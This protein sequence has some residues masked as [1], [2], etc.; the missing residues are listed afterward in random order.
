MSARQDLELASKQAL[1]G[2]RR[3]GP[4]P[5]GRTLVFGTYLMDTDP[6]DES[7]TPWLLSIGFWEAWVHIAIASLVKKGMYCVDVGANMGYFTLLMARQACAPC[8][9]RV[10]AIEPYPPSVAL[11]RN[12]IEIN[13]LQTQV[14]VLDAAV[15]SHK[16]LHVHI[17]EK[18]KGGVSVTPMTHR[19]GGMEGHAPELRQDTPLVV[20]SVR[21]IT[22]DDATA[23]MRRV[24]FVK[25]DVEGSEVEVWLT[26]YGLRHKNPR[27]R[28]VIE[29]SPDRQYDMWG[30][31][32]QMEDEGNEVFMVTTDG[33]FVPMEQARPTMQAIH[34]QPGQYATIMVQGRR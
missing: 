18:H 24:D 34:K 10:L 2:W 20:Q 11:L 32:R 33:G 5:Q 29:V 30:L 27:C 3:R 26:S 4:Q 6:E 21:G 17:P 9:G 22:L 25:V 15:S 1:D 16:E 28:W 12:N 23:H 31:I 19:D 14:D 8:G 7:I 13:G